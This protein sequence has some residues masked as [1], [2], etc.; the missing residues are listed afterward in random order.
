MG[1]SSCR[2]NAI[3]QQNLSATFYL[4]RALVAGL[5]EAM[6]LGHINAFPL[7]WVLFF[8][9]ISISGDFISFT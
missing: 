6:N 4:Y 7:A 8:K 1:F 9:L 2:S 5:D 3:G